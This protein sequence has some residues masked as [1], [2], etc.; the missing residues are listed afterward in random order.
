MCSLRGPLQLE[1]YNL[2]DAV[3]G[4]AFGQL[5]ISSTPVGSFKFALLIFYLEL[6]ATIPCESGSRLQE[7]GRD[8][9]HSEPQPNSQ[10]VFSNRSARLP[11]AALQGKLV[12]AV[13]TL[14]QLPLLQLVACGLCWFICDK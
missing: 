2:D 12:A 5:A 1:L 9:V 3:G 13:A 10:L 4:G 11:G 6:R 7:N 14:V 8:L